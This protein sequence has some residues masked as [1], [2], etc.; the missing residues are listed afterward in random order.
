MLDSLFTPVSLGGADAPGR[1]PWAS[2]A[3]GQL[4]L[5]STAPL[6]GARGY[7]DY[8]TLADATAA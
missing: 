4:P 3:S 5:I 6:P 1:I 8:P 2:A 7:S